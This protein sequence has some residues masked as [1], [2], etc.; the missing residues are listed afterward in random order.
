MK[1]QKN[2]SKIDVLRWIAILPATILLLLIYLTFV[3]DLFYKFFNLLFQEELVANIVSIIN[4]VLMPIL[5]AASAYYISPKFK[6]NSTLIL[7]L[8]FFI[9]RS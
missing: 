4:M 8:F 2:L 9:V 6:Y 7:I 1:K 3:V 5:I